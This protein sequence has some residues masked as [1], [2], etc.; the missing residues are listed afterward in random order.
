VHSNFSALPAYDMKVL[1]TACPPDVLLAAFD[2]FAKNF[3]AAAA[4]PTCGNSIPVRDTSL[5]LQTLRV[6]FASMCASD[7][8]GNMCWCVPPQRPQLPAVDFVNGLKG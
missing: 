6:T 7:P 5:L 8:A 3:E 1:C 4:D 2:G